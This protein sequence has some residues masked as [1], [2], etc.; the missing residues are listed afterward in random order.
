MRI[1]LCV[2]LLCVGFTAGCSDDETRSKPTG[3]SAAQLRALRAA[4]SEL[5]ERLKAATAANESLA[6][7]NKSLAQQLRTARGDGPSLQNA[8]SPAPVDGR[9]GSPVVAAPAEVVDP[10]NLT[11][12]E[13][14]TLAWTKLSSGPFED[15]P[16]TAVKIRDVADDVAKYKGR[17]V[18]IN[19]VAVDARI[20]LADGVYLVWLKDDRGTLFGGAD[21]IRLSLNKR[22]ADDIRTEFPAG[23]TIQAKLHCLIGTVPQYIGDPSPAAWIY[24]LDAVARLGATP[25]R[26]TPTGVSIP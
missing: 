20:E 24:R 26:F 19:D 18:E 9:N 10:K 22:M 5:T 14:I 2:V 12:A 7:E 3:D 25:I 11:T 6:Q 8:V 23:S 21:S 13:R 15:R 17:C 1:L 16:S 4:N